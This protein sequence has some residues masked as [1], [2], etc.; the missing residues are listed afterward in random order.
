MIQLRKPPSTLTGKGTIIAYG[1]DADTLYVSP[2][3]EC[4]ACHASP[5]SSWKVD[6]SM[7]VGV[8]AP[9][10][11]GSITGNDTKTTISLS[12]GEFAMASANITYNSNPGPVIVVP[13]SDSIS[14]PELDFTTTESDN[15]R[16]GQ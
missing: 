5:H 6:V 14:I 16:V 8:T 4:L 3:N 7:G 2:N 10:F 13:E 11:S 9:G 15:T 1:S 12:L